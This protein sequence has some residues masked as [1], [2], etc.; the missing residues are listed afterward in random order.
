MWITLQQHTVVWHFLFIRWRHRQSHNRVCPECQSA[1]KMHASRRM[2]ACKCKWASTS[3]RTHCE[4]HR[5][6]FLSKKLFEWVE[7]WGLRRWQY[8]R[9]RV[10]IRCTVKCNSNRPYTHL[11]HIAHTKCSIYLFKWRTKTCIN[12]NMKIIMRSKFSFRP[13]GILYHV[14]RERVQKILY[15]FIYINMHHMRISMYIRWSTCWLR[16]LS[17]LHTRRLKNTDEREREREQSKQQ[18]RAKN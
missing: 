8:T 7:A 4:H 13:I 5:R 6:C 9:V 11:L 10:C 14:R 18:V 12:M 16:L 1:C 17:A 2:S 3:K 15:L